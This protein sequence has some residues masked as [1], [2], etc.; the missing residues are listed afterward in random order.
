MA[1]ETI[2]KKAADAEAQAEAK[3]VAAQNTEAEKVADKRAKEHRG[4]D[5]RLANHF[6]GMVPVTDLKSLPSVKDRNVNLVQAPSVESDQ[7]WTVQ[8]EVPTTD[9]AS[10]PGQYVQPHELPTREGLEALG[11][12]PLPYL[13]GVAVRKA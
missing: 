3:T 6:A 13:A 1:S 4:D 8:S 10:I 12:D 2:D 11:I 7:G 5:E 9:R